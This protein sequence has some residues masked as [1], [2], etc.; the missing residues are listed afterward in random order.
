MAFAYMTLHAFYA[1]NTTLMELIFNDMER[2]TAA[3]YFARGQEPHDFKARLLAI[4]DKF[5]KPEKAAMSSF[6]SA[7]EKVEQR[8]RLRQDL[9]LFEKDLDSIGY[10][11]ISRTEVIRTLFKLGYQRLEQLRTAD[12]RTLLAISGIGPVVLREIREAIEVHDRDIAPRPVPPKVVKP[13]KPRLTQS[14]LTGTRRTKKA[15]KAG[16]LVLVTDG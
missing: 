11:P 5:K 2:E 16:Q 9:N 6:L 13:R 7:R 1:G 8:Y 4:A 12:D 15:E 14:I 3:A 10:L